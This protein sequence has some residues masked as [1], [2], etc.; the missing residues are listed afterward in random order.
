[1][2]FKRLIYIVSIVLLIIVGAN[3]IGETYSQF[4]TDASSRGDAQI[5]KWMVALKDGEVELENRFDVT[6][7]STSNNEGKVA[8]NRLAPGTAGQATL[9][10]DLTN[11]EVSVDYNITVDK[12]VLENQ[13]GSSNITLTM[14]DSN[15]QII[16]FGKN[17]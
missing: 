13:I 11:T 16:N 2:N 17:K 15:N 10:L 9:I 7:V 3:Y 8:S 1:M 5:A 14:L 4:K 12:R 6:F